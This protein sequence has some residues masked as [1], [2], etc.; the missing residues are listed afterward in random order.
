MCYV[1]YLFAPQKV[2]KRLGFKYVGMCCKKSGGLLLCNDRSGAETTGSFSA[3]TATRSISENAHE[4]Q[5]FST[6]LRK[7]KKCQ[8]T[9]VANQQLFLLAQ[10][11]NLCYNKSYENETM[12]L[13][14]GN[15]EK[16]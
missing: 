3:H 6:E 13:N 16:N 14:G 2:V 7:T 10:H 5:N 12:D 1:K 9:I 8:R 11:K 15:H 4:T